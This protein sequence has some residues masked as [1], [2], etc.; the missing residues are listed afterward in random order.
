M[1]IRGNMQRRG[2]ME[3]QCDMSMRCSVIDLTALANASKKTCIYA[4]KLQKR[5]TYMGGKVTCRSNV[6]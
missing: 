6:T 5:P 4:G 1:Q 3:I 2:N